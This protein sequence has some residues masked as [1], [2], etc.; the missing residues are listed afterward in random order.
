[1]FAGQQTELTPLLKWKKS[2]FVDQ[3]F[4]QPFLTGGTSILFDF[5]TVTLFKQRT[6][7]KVTLLTKIVTSLMDNPF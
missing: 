3:W 6:Y 2:L 1:M 7:F 4:F 5:F